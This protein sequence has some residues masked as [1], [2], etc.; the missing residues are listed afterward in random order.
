MALMAEIQATH[1]DRLVSGKVAPGPVHMTD[2]AAAAGELEL[3]PNGIFSDQYGTLEFQTPIAEMTIASV[4]KRES[5][6]YKRWRNGYERAWSNFFDPIAIQF[7]VTDDKLA[8]DVTVMPLIVRSEYRTLLTFS[9]GAKVGNNDG[10]P[11]QAALLHLA[12]ALNR[13]SPIAKQYAGFLGALSPQAN[14]LSWIGDTVALYFDDG[15]FFRELA[16]VESEDLDEFGEENLHRLPIALHIGVRSGLQLTAFLVGVRT[17]IEQTSPGMTVWETLEHND[18]PY[19]RISASERARSQ[20]R[21]SGFDQASLYYA[22]SGESLIVTLDESLLKRAIDRREARRNIEDEG[23][24]WERPGAPWIGDNFNVQ[25]DSA[26][27]SYI[28]KPLHKYYQQH[29]QVLC[30]NNIAILNEW[31]RRYPDRDPVEVHEAY[32]Q[33]KLVCPGGGQYR[34]NESWQTMESTVYGHPG[35]P[36]DGP[37]WP[38]SLARLSHGNFGLTFEDDGLRARIEVLRK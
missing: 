23:K 8:A 29:M 33:R 7:E 27:L 9:Q 15:D 38:A 6:L 20:N 21:G 4:T 17:L 3:Q 34:W 11:H 13:E 37:T 25:I 26:L 31:K 19:V 30:W 1:L 10:D 12:L 35:E 14:P 28:E 32:W 5:E 2:L 16:N 36:Q 22:A 18:H 24:I